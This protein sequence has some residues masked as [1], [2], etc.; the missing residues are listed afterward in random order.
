MNTKQPP[1]A[2][3]SIAEWHDAFAD[4]ASPFAAGIRNSRY[5]DE[6]LHAI[7]SRKPELSAPLTRLFLLHSLLFI[8]RSLAKHPEP[9]LGH[10]EFM[11]Y[12]TR[13]AYSDLH[14]KIAQLLAAGPLIAGN[15]AEAQMVDDTL[16]LLRQEM[17]VEQ[18]P[19][20]FYLAHY[21]QLWRQWMEADIAHA[22]TLR[23]EL[24]VLDSAWDKL[25]PAISDFPAALAAS[26]LH[27][28]LGE[29]EA[30]FRWL[31]HAR[32]SGSPLPYA[33]QVLA[34]LQEISD[35]GEGMR[36]IA[37]LENTGPK[38]NLYRSTFMTAFSD[39]WNRALIQH[40]EE[41]PR[42]WQSL[43]EMLPF[44]STIYL[45]QLH[46]RG[47]WDLWI[48]YQLASGYEPLSF[49]VAELKPIEKEA[50]ELLL[51]FYHQ[52]VERYILEK[53][54]HSYKAAVKLLKRLAKL[55]KKLKQDNRWEQFLAGLVSRNSRL[56][57]L[58][59][60]MRK[61]KLIP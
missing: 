7:Y 51:P 41:E 21:G 60:E 49:R 29:D 15:S 19:D 45:E 6:V 58:Q 8:C 34:L 17:L 23:E 38:L 11:G 43:R 4:I 37:W 57:A 55:Y 14:G 53:N 13:T 31:E 42:L 28:Y 56:R 1:F 24:G 30:A 35:R 52:A 32:A 9:R 48:D 10:Q 33:E 46:M 54:R 36:L 25:G 16:N 20:V 39:L 22:P 26:R 27:Y 40:P 47:K 59:E 12:F 5:A 2:A 44:S 18:Q 3:M 50:P 61:G